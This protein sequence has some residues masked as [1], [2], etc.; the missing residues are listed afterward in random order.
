MSQ[1]P[2]VGR[3]V[4]FNTILTSLKFGYR[5]EEVATHP[6]I[7]T[8]VISDTIVNLMVLPDGSIPF[9]KTGVDMTGT[10]HWS[11]PERV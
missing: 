8:K 10:S 11:W 1:K 4:I 3:I 7:I 5:D 9:T 2:S 6:A